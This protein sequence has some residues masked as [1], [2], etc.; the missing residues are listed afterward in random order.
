MNG[1]K[2]TSDRLFI[3]ILCLHIGPVLHILFEACDQGIGRKPGHTDGQVHRPVFDFFLQLWSP[4]L[5]EQ[6][7]SDRHAQAFYAWVLQPL[8]SFR[9][10]ELLPS[11][12]SQ[13]FPQE[14]GKP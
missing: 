12:S 3:G 10:P 1:S 11:A 9:L 4:P 13:Q 8:Q 2:E 14:Q 6:R 5:P 7:I